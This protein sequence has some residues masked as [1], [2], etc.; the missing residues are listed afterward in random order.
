MMDLSYS[1]DQKT[2]QAK[3]R[4]TKSYLWEQ[5]Q[6]GLN[7]GFVI[8]FYSCKILMKF[9]VCNMKSSLITVTNE[10]DHLKEARRLH[11]GQDINEWFAIHSLDTIIII[12]SYSLQT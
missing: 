9:R 4:K 12:S 5:G 1:N 11:S 10:S 6:F 7:C 2:F 8:T 3:K